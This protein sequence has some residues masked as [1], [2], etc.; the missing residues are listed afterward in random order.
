MGL[1][2]CWVE[3]EKESGNNKRRKWLESRVYKAELMRGLHLLARTRSR[4][5]SG[6]SKRQRFYGHFGRDNP[7]S[8]GTRSAAS[9]DATHYTRSQ[10]Y[11]SHYNNPKCLQTSPNVP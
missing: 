8:W 9:L 3:A 1:K 4:M 7:L 11:L 6:V 5:G 10:Q 2:E